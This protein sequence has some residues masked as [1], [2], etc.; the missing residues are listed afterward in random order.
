MQDLRGKSAVVTGGGSGIG[1]AIALALADAGTDVVIADIDR[2]AGEKV[3][4]EIRA[5]GRRGVAVETDVTQRA[6]VERLADA[7]FGALGAVH[8]LCNNAGVFRGSPLDRAPDADWEWLMAVNLWGVVHGI[9]VFLPRMRDQG[10]GGHVVNTA[11]MA[12]Q[13]GFPGLGIYTATKF[14]VVGISEVLAQDLAPYGIGVSGLCPGIVS[15]RIWD[16]ARQ[17]PAAFGGPEPAPEGGGEALAQ[18][19]IDP[20]IVGAEVLRAIRENR[21]YV[22]THPDMR[23]MLEARLRRVLADY[24][25]LPRPGGRSS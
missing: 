15:T 5:R 9:Q 21:L 25:A 2:A 22:F 19:G 14:A 17:R 4:G 13:L 8:V 11:S 3:A 24:D 7:A 16:G 10:Q 12:G 6:S 23:G 20:A 1:R 18:I